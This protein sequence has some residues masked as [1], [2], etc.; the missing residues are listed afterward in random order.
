VQD[1]EGEG[2][3]VEGEDVEVEGVEVEGVVEVVVG[4]KA[5]VKVGT[6]VER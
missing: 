1:V 6:E 2:E 4:A 3:D 5:R